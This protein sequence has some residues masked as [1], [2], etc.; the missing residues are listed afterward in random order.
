MYAMLD[1][2]VN[3]EGY[4]TFWTDSAIL[5]QGWNKNKYLIKAFIGG[6]RDLWHKLGQ[7]LEDRGEGT[8]IVKHIESQWEQSEAMLK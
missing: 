2:L 1:A 6:N 4:M 7:S 8:V 3:T 5:C